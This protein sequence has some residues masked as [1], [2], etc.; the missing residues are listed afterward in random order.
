MKQFVI[1]N[2]AL[3]ESSPEFQSEL[4][5]AY[6]QKLRPL[7]RC[8]EPPVPMYIARMDGQFLVKRMPLSG[9]QHDPVCPSYDP[10]L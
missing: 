6:E 9:R 5:R 4:A 7:C 3:E 10:T 8:R 1:G 2:Q